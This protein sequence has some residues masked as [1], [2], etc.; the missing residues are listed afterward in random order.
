MQSPPHTSFFPIASSEF[1]IDPNMGSMKDAFSVTCKFEKY[2]IGE[3]K[4]WTCINATKYDFMECVK[5]SVGCS[6]REEEAVED[7]RRFFALQNAQCYAIHS[8]LST[9]PK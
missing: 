7:M 3:D 9:G 4:A 5:V 1:Y 6:E 8:C 2:Q